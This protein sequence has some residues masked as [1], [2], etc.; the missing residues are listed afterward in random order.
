MSLLHAAGLTLLPPAGGFLL[1]KWTRQEVKNW[2]DPK[3]DKPSWRPPNWYNIEFLVSNK[4]EL[5]K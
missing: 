5:N 2:Y 1:S 3:L 4:N